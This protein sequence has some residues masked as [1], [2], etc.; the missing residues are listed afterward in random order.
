MTIAIA[1]II[2]VPEIA[3]ARIV[4]KWIRVD[5]PNRRRPSASVN[6]FA[7]IQFCKVFGL[8]QSHF[9][10]SGMAINSGINSG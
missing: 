10:A 9:A 4:G 7:V 8:A 3:L 2:R 6:R 5:P 1:A